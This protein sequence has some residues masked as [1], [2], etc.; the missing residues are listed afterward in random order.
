MC[1][2]Y[3]FLV[4]DVKD[5]KEGEGE[6][7]GGEKCLKI[8]ILLALC[9]ALIIHFSLCPLWANNIFLFTNFQL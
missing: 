7:L 8:K 2:L 6:F 1:C 3:E 5:Q 4:P 9:G